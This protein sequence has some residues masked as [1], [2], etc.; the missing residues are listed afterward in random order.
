M[1]RTV[2][3]CLM[4]GAMLGAPECYAALSQ[5]ANTTLVQE[6]GSPAKKVLASTPLVTIR[7]YQPRARYEESL[8][9]T[10][11]KAFEI[12]PKVNFDVVSVVPFAASAEKYKENIAL[13]RKN[14]EGVIG[15]L[16]AAGIPKNQVS[17]RYEDGAVSTNN[18]IRIFVQ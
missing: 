12:K 4:I 11:K 2:F 3:S 16:A 13:S 5:D 1:R 10:V 6:E 8:Y 14:A 18:E 15:D 9:T 7:F 17:I